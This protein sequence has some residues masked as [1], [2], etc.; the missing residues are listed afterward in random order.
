M[1]DVVASD[2]LTV[3]LE[4]PGYRVVEL[5]WRKEAIDIFEVFSEERRCRCVAKA[6]RA[7][8]AADHPRAAAR[9]LQEGRLLQALDH[10]HLVRAYETVEH[11]RPVVILETLTGETLEHLIDRRPRRR[12]P[13]V[14]LAFLGVHL[15]SAV[16]YLHQHGYLHRDLK[17]SNVVVQ[18]GRAKVLD[19]SIAKPPG[20]TKPGTGTRGYLAPEQ[21]RGEE[22]T[23]A[24]D[25]WGIGA[26]LFSAATGQPP[27]PER[28]DADDDS[29]PQAF[30]PAP[31]VRTQRRLPAVLADVIDACLDAAPER[32]PAVV[33]VHGALEDFAMSSLGR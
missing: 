17:P 11:P 14:E 29:H 22:L 32:R 2:V 5:L 1:T 21:A 25:V 20:R 7:D 26:T 3:D 19:L 13:A 18:Q 30:R 15:A 28:P 33:E 6:L 4:L 9:L 8:R 16:H 31:R 12:L 10:P 27:F 24:T 23:A